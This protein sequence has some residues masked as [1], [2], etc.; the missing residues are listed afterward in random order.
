MI[1][2]DSSAVTLSVLSNRLLEL[3]HEETARGSLQILLFLSRF[4]RG[5]HLLFLLTLDLFVRQLL[6]LIVAV[7]R[8]PLR[9]DAS[10]DGKKDY[11]NPSTRD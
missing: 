8:V 5:S 9:H 11:Q 1:E 4:G 10:R 6:G 3:L 7:A 2:K